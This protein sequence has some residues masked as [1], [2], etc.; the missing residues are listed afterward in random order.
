MSWNC[1]FRLSPTRNKVAPMN[2]KSTGDLRDAS[3]GAKTDGIHMP[4]YS[5]DPEDWESFRASAHAALDDAIEFLRSARDRPVWRPVPEHVR[6]VLSEE[7]PLDGQPLDR[8]YQEFTELILPYSTGNTHP[9]FFGWVHGTG[10]ATGI[11][12][13][14][15]A[16]AMNANCGGRDHGAIYVERAVVDWCKKV[17]DLPEGASGLVVSGTSIANLIAIAVA[18]NAP[19][20]AAARA[21]GVQ[22]CRNRLTAYASAEVHDC[23]AKAMEMLGLGAANLRKIPVDDAFRINLGLLRD[24]I[25]DDRKNGCEPFC[26]VGTAGTVNTGAIDDLDQLANVCAAE[27]IWFHVDGAFGA[28]AVLSDELKPLLK[29]IE[30]ADSIA[31]D[32]HKW[33]HVPYDAGCVLIR[34]GDLHRASFS[35]RPAYLNRLPRGLAG[36]QDWPCEFGPELSRGFRAL[37]IWFAM[38]QHGTRQFGRL[39]AQNCN[40][41]SYLAEAIAREADF[42]LLAPVSLNIVCFRFRAEG[43]EGPELDNLN[44]EIVEELQESGVAAPSTT[45]LRGKLAIRVNITNHRCRRD[46]FDLLLRAIVDAGRRRIVAHLGEA[47]R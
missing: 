23:V 46:D 32:F 6:A 5:L 18:R 31:F 12:A 13:E 28:L 1:G 15:L 43:L 2:E 22:D 44:E 14:M 41:A 17:F 45:R 10:M 30:R 26:V 24:R 42:E 35:T 3:S 37:K 9:R 39:V 19:D 36:G 34:R 4:E 7:V 47:R 27:K 8:V 33:M 25:A 40:Q 38:K 20:V 21:H 16:A 11:V 29:G